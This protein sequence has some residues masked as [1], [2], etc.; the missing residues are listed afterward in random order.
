[1][2]P[3]TRA[4]GLGALA[5]ALLLLAGCG[6]R[7]ARLTPLTS[8]LD[9]QLSCSQLKAEIEVNDLKT[10]DLAGE[11][12]TETTDAAARALLVNPL[13]VDLSDSEKR[14][15]ESLAARNAHLRDLIAARCNAA[16]ATAPQPQAQ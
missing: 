9:D 7:V 12:K 14:E 16:P 13:F 6:G 11:R 10:R 15:Q 5:A 3:P 1:M 8:P 2:I 4:R